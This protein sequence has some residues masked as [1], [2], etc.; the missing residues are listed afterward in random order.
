ML[1]V[2]LIELSMSNLFFVV[3]LAGMSFLPTPTVESETSE[4]AWAGENVTARCFIGVSV[5]HGINMTWTSLND[6]EVTFT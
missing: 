3:F 2:C 4:F 5:D 6:T 1:N